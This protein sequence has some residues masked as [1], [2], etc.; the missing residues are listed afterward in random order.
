[1]P[2]FCRFSK[3]F[4]YINELREFLFDR[5]NPS[6]SAIYKQARNLFLNSSSFKLPN[7]LDM[8]SSEEFQKKLEIVNEK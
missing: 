7:Y 3:T 6:E 2:G 8:S 1:M 4:G 5:I